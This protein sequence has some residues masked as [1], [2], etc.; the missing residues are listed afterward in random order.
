MMMPRFLYRS[1][2]LLYWVSFRVKRHVTPAGAMMTAVFFITALFGLNMYKTT[3]YQVMAFSLSLLSVS[4]VLSLM[5]FRPKLRLRHILPAYG[6][7][8]EK[9]VYSIEITNLGLKPEKGIILYEDP[10]DPRPDLNTLLT[11][12]EPYEHLRNAWDRKTLYYRWAWLVLKAGKASIRPI[13]LPD[14]PPGEPIRM[15][16]DFTPNYRGYLLFTGVTLARPDILGLFMRNFRIKKMEKLLV[17]PRR[18]PL[19]PPDLTSK[20]QYHPGGVNLASSIGNSDEFMSLRYYRP[21]DP[22]H[23]IHW[24][25][26]ARTGEL[27]IKEFED[28]F[29]V[30][31]VL[32]LDTFVS[33]E[34]ERVFEEAVS[35]AASY[36]ASMGPHDAILDL[37]LGGREMYTFSSGRGL[38]GSE[39]ML[40]ILSCVESCRDKTIL[41]LKPVL[42]ASLKTIS[43][44]IFVFSGW[45][46][47]HEEI[48]RIIHGA[49]LPAFIIVLAE[50]AAQKEM[51]VR[52][53]RDSPYP[54]RVVQIGA[55]PEELSIP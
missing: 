27:V 48:C 28:E 44:A 8:G 41:E 12:K 16:S 3:L 38:G 45:S 37:I 5:P 1:Y 55:V 25:T 15:T 33:P 43:G 13:K 20:R 52:E 30:R 10:A 34:R 40:E 23:H 17:L 18:Y 22:L 53:M 54:V 19:D 35:I 50:D 21:G 47:D 49:L 36:I 31:Y 14:L 51:I 32:A 11:R 4:A 29:F 9:S 42:E 24:R 7:V 2:W 6:T 39:K 46:R 26:F